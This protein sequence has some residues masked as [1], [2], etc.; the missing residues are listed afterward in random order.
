MHN[1]FFP[2][3][4]E[5]MKYCGE[6]LCSSVCCLFAC[7]LVSQKPHGETSTSLYM[8]TLAVAQSSEV[9][10]RYVMYVRYGD[11]SCYNIMVLIARHTCS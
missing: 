10:L 6:R 8:L 2:A 1:H 3:L 9:E 5:G 4:Q 11:E 7:L